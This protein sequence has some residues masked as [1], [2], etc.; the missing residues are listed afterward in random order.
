[1]NEYD[2]DLIVNLEPDFEIDGNFVM[3]G[4][5]QVLEGLAN[6]LAFH[7]QDMSIEESSMTLKELSGNEVVLQID[8]IKLDY[9]RNIM[10]LTYKE[11]SD[12]AGGTFDFELQATYAGIIYD[13]INRGQYG[14]YRDSYN[15]SNGEEMWMAVTQ[16]ESD[17]ARRAF[18][19]VD[20]PGRKAVY[21]IK[22]GHDETLIAQS[23]GELLSSNKSV[24][25]YPGYVWSEFAQTNAMSSYLIAFVVSDLGVVESEP[26]SNGVIHKAWA[27][28]E[29][30]ADGLAEYVKEV[31]PGC[32]EAYEQT[33]GVPYSINKLEQISPPNKGGAM[34]NWGLI[35]Y[36]ETGLLID[37]DTASA[38]QWLS[39]VSVQAH[40]IAHQWFGD[41]VTCDWWSYIWLNEG[42]A[43]Y[44]SYWGAEHVAKNFTNFDRYI[45]DDLFTALH[46]D[47]RLSSHPISTEIYNPDEAYFGSITY[48]KGGSLIRMAESF[49][50]T[51]TWKKGLHNYLIKFSF[52]GAVPDN[53][54]FEWDIAAKEDGTL[55][56]NVYVKTI[57]DTW[58]LQQNYPV[59]HVK[60]NYTSNKAVLTQERFLV[61]PD[62]EDTDNLSWWIPITYTMVNDTDTN[63]ENVYNDNV[64]F[65]A[66]TSS[67]VM[68]VGSS[69]KAVI[70]NKKFSAFY[71]T[72][73]DPQNWA[74]IANELMDNY[75]NI[76]LTNRA[77]LIDDSYN[78]AKANKITGYDIPLSIVEYLSNEVNYVPLKMAREVLRDIYY[79]NEDLSY[80]YPLLLSLEDTFE[81]QYERVGLA[82]NIHGSWDYNMAQTIIVKA[83]CSQNGT[84]CSTDAMEAFAEYMTVPEPDNLALN[85]IN[86]HVRDSVY[87]AAIRGGSQKE[88]DFLTKRKEACTNPQEKSNI[89]AGLSCRDDPSD[90]LDLIIYFN[91]FTGDYSL[92]ET[93]DALSTN[94][95]LE[96]VVEVI[97]E[98]IDLAP[99]TIHLLAK[100]L[101]GSKFDHRRRQLIYDLAEIDFARNGFNSWQM[102]EALIKIDDK[103][104]KRC[105]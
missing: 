1:M 89:N 42:F 73:Y 43:Q 24:D 93:E 33:F 16:F 17:N 21:N 76:H 50:T 62:E 40:E 31:G 10:A 105:N 7:F 95:S 103:C 55:G 78:L 35:I 79:E 64:W 29:A 34:E 104:G 90:L 77:Q 63:F 96:D 58:T 91:L 51:E 68:D 19:C 100:A 102:R 61:N 26:Q 46:A 60:R 94:P 20:E 18:P 56:P 13:P 54:F 98:E 3:R 15:N 70:F 47:D 30:I 53:L 11:P 80:T 49:L 44:V 12:T 101:L 87:C 81:A 71:R 83:T 75:E 67:F 85:P 23:N 2:L 48:S 27:R 82:E 22:L 38:S 25:G 57:M 69:D 37:L 9:A 6:E 52:E 28:K 74:L 14:F 65:P 97:M 86:R 39:M 72:N 92:E 84:K 45:A 36:R 4:T 99:E 5:A 32:I 59:V 66:S 8:V 41:L 88:H